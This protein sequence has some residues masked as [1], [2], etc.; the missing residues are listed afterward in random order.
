MAYEVVT[1]G[2]CVYEVDLDQRLE[3]EALLRGMY[4]DFRPFLKELRA[5]NLARL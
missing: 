1:T 2:H 5:R 4:F 3:Y